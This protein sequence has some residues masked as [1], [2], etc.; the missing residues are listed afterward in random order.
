MFDFEY[1]SRGRARGAETAATTKMAGGGQATGRPG[2][3]EV[4]K[5]LSIFGAVE[6]ELRKHRLGGRV[7]YGIRGRA[8]KRD[9]LFYEYQRAAETGTYSTCAVEVS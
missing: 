4:D 9:D 3:E 5:A 8:H 6:L 2:G 7:R 1:D